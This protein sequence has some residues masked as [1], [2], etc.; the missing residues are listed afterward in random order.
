M[1]NKHSS[2]IVVPIEPKYTKDKKNVYWN[3]KIVED[4]LVESFIDLGDGYAKDQFDIFY[5][6]CII[7]DAD[8]ITFTVDENGNARDKDNFYEEGYIIDKNKINSKLN[9]FLI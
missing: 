9:T 6:G 5:K 4:I 2:S 8:I 7:K 1:G 3:G